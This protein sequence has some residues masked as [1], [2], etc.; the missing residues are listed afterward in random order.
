MRLLL[1]SIY[2]ITLV[3]CNTKTRENYTVGYF[4]IQELHAGDVCANQIKLQRESVAIKCR[5]G[6]TIKDLLVLLDDKTKQSIILWLYADPSDP[7][8]VGSLASYDF[9]RILFYDN[10]DFIA[11]L[12]HILPKT[13]QNKLR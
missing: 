5:A 9:E 12:K 6:W 4:E 11:R 2:V 7:K 13:S 1:I 10:S 3:S 8:R